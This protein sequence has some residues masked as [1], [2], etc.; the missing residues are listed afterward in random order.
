MAE[1]A[2]CLGTA[3][4]LASGA[5]PVDALMNPPAAIIRSKALR[6]TIRSRTT[7]KAPA[8]HGSMVRESPSRKWRMW[9][10]HTVVARSGPWAMPLIMNPHIPQMPSRQSWSK[11]MGSSPPRMRPSLTTS[12]ISRNDMSGLIPPAW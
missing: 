2:S 7:G 5:L 3:M 6:S 9:S 10:W 1:S 12:S 11:A 4:L 8:L